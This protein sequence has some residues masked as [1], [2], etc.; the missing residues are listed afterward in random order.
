M[1]PITLSGRLLIV[2]LVGRYLTNQ[3]IRRE[4]T[5]NRIA[6]LTPRPCDPVVLCGISTCFQVLSPCP[7]QIVHALLTRPPLEYVSLWP[8]PPFLI[9]PLDLHVL[10]TPPAFVLSQDQTLLFNPFPPAHLGANLDKRLSSLIPESDLFFPCA[11]SS[12]LYRFQ[13]SRRR[14]VCASWR[15]FPATALSIIRLSLPFVNTFFRKSSSLFLHYMLRFLQ[16]S[17]LLSVCVLGMFHRFRHTEKRRETGLSGLPP[18]AS[19]PYFFISSM[20]CM[21]MSSESGSPS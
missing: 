12:S 1:W 17:R 16:C 6:P 20:N 19:F 2:A 3:L 10:G 5:P 8:K 4:L 11:C 14:F 15:P 18:D 9:S 13:G 21:Q 7:G